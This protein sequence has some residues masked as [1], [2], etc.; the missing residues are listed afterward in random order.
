M[1]PIGCASQIRRVA[2]RRELMR[3]DAKP[4]SY[5][6]SHACTRDSRNEIHFWIWFLNVGDSTLISVGLSAQRESPWLSPRTCIP[7][8]SHSCFLGRDQRLC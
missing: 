7:S 2:P 6:L 5:P 3:W 4:T 1:M 8:L